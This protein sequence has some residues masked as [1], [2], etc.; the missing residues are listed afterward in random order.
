MLTDVELFRQG[1]WD[2]GEKGIQL[3]AMDSAHV[4]LVS[5]LLEADGFDRYRC[6]RDISLG[7]DMESMAKVL[8]C[9]AKDDIIEISAKG[10]TPDNLKFTFEAPDQE[11]I[12][13]YEMKLMNIEQEHLQ[14]PDTDYSVTIK[15]PAA[16]SS[17]EV[18]DIF[19]RCRH[20]NCRGLSEIYLSLATPSQYPP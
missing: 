2:C 10:D 9:A 6:D 3:Q 20:M 14:I 12:S 8:K 5:V 18:D 11:R 17:I 7:V 15:V 13:E 1:T 4:C 19:C 16:A